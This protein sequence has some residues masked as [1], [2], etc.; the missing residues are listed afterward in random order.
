[1]FAAASDNPARG[2]LIMP[3]EVLDLLTNKLYD[4]GENGE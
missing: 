1:M 4:K 2:F 3:N